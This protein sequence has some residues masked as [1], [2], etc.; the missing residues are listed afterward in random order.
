MHTVKPV[1][2]GH[3]CIQAKVS[4]FSRQPYP[5][6]PVIYMLFWIYEL[7]GVQKLSNYK[8]CWPDYIFFKS[9]SYFQFTRKPKNSFQ[10]LKKKKK[11]HAFKKVAENRS[12][13]RKKY[14]NKPL[15]KKKKRSHNACVWM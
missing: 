1:K 4:L 14:S 7:P 6:T 3:P 9:I 15:K 11:S 10:K 5:F 2:E 12:H 13:G 8:K